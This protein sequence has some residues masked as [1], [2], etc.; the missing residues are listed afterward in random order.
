[1]DTSEF[2]GRVKN[3][4]FAR[5]VNLKGIKYIS[6]GENSSLGKGCIVNAWDYILGIEYS[7][8]LIIGKN[9]FL[10]EYDH[11]ICVNSITIGTNVTLG[12][13]VTITD[14]SHGISSFDEMNLHPLK[15]KI[16][17]KGPIV[18]KDNVW[19]DDKVTILPGVSIGR[20]VVIGANSVVT[21]SIPNYCVVAG[22]PARIVSC[23]N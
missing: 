16:Y 3:V 17:S 22:N 2:K 23:R 18:I 9:C 19:I 12:R 11:I 1:M 15:R 5:Y 21:K 14:N 7:P 10:G 6:I 4:F 8:S 13:W 20:G